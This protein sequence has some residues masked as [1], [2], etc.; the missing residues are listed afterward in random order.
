LQ[1]ELQLLLDAELPRDPLDFRGRLDSKGERYGKVLDFRHSELRVVEL[2]D[3]LCSKMG[4]YALWVPEAEGRAAE[5]VRVS[6]DRKHEEAAADPTLQGASAKV[7]ALSREIEGFCAVLI[8]SAEDEVRAAAELVL[9]EIRFYVTNVEGRA[10]EPGSFTARHLRC[11]AVSLTPRSPTQLAAAIRSDALNETA[12][13]EK[14]L[15]RSW[16]S[17]CRG[18]KRRAKTA[19]SPA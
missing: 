16:S 5:W 1:V 10:S 15:C 7:K 6:G 9:K 2:L 4:D 13:T 12:V 19:A 14:F 3:G 11:F 17:H 8:E 18:V